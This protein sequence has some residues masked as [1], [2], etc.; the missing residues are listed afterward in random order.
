MEETLSLKKYKKKELIK[1]VENYEYDIK[2]L[3]EELTR[4]SLREIQVEYVV[5]KDEEDDK[6]LQYIK[7]RLMIIKDPHRRETYNNELNRLLKLTN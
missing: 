5:V 2:T 1:L 4:L 7:N 3:N 6:T